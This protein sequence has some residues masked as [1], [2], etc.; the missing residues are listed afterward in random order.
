MY[1]TSAKFEYTHIIELLLH[2]RKKINL[3]TR[4]TYMEK[5][6]IWKRATRNF[7]PTKLFPSII[8]SITKNI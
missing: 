3:F 2:D 4:I 7:A 6:M 8:I 5:L 1:Y